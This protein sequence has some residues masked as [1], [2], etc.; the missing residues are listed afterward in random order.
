M[1]GDERRAQLLATAREVFARRGF[2]GTSM[3]EVAEAAGITKP[4]LY[5]HFAS[6]RDLY[7]ELLDDMRVRLVHELDHV[8]FAEDPETRLAEGVEAYFRFVANNE[9]AFRLMVE[10]SAADPEVAKHV[11]STR[12]EIADRVRRVLRATRDSPDPD[13]TSWAVVG[14]AELVSHWWLDNPSSRVTA[15]GLARHVSRLAWHGVSGI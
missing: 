10:A 12:E 9:A 14:M 4:V 5:Q 2:H 1:S 7:M 3:D 6:K 13:V 11:Q 8:P 15:E